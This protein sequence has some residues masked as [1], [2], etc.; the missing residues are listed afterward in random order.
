M[1]SD[2][3]SSRGEGPSTPDGP[4]GGGDTE[5]YGPDDG[6]LVADGL[7][8]RF[9]GL[10]AVDDLSFAVQEQEILGFIGPNGA[11]K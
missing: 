8:K 5:S 1:S 6:I 3:G 7:T 9:G 11:G 10:V 2:S 4:A